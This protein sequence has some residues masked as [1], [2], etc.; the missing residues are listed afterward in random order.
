MFFSK[1]WLSSNL[2]NKTGK[3]TFLSYFFF[4]VSN[5]LFCQKQIMLTAYRFYSQKESYIPNTLDT[6]D[7]Y[8]QD[9]SYFSG[10][11]ILHYQQPIKKTTNNI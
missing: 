6:I 9:Y 4:L 2:F 11:V 10:N 1:K 3:R 8:K 5:N 7:I